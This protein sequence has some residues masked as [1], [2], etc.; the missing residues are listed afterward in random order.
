MARSFEMVA[1]NVEKVDTKYRKITTEIPNAQSLKII[2]QLRKYE[3]ISMSGQP[4]IVWDKADG[5]NV[6]D[7]YGN[8]WIDFSSGVLVANSGHGNEEVKKAIIDQVEHGLLFNYCFPSEIRASLVKRLIEIVPEPL[9]KV[10]LLSTGA[11]STECAIK[12]CRTYGQKIGGKKKI[13]V[14]TFLDDFHG[15]TMGALLAG[16]SPKAK[17]WVVNKD[18][19]IQQMPFPNSFKYDWADEKNPEYS[20][21]K[22][23]N[24]WLS[25]LDEQ[26]INPEHIAGIIPETF[27]GGWVQ[28]MPVGF[29]KRLREFCDKYNILLAFDEVQSGF[30]RSGKLFAYQHYGVKADLIC[31]G[32]GLS[33]SLPISAVIGRSDIMDLYGPNEMTSTHT[34]NTVCVAAALANVHYMMEHKLIENA[35]TL[36]GI[37]RDLLEGLKKKYPDIIGCVNGCGLAWGVIF[38]K[39]GTKEID[40]DL[41]HDIVR[42]SIEKGLMFFAPVG[43]GATL[44]ICPPLVINE[45][46]LIEG[47]EVFAQ[48]I[49]KAVSEKVLAE[50][51]ATSDNN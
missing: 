30:G 20:D 27:Q 26:N 8:K 47:L 9:N 35:A 2:E 31:C 12:L 33:S 51:S 14:I 1:K 25:Y 10:F 29:V 48:A 40:P 6:Y 39:N 4:L 13:K 46:A 18:P 28:L 3:P 7:K 34:G 16:G 17:E 36:E 50:A 37:C 11:E 49:E 43:A 42:I 44:K 41:A 23:F 22:C 21:D 5:I 32:K 45:E 19:D 24:T 15:R 38:V